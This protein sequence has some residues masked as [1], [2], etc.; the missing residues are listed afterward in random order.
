MNQKME[1]Y[2]D[3]IA[4]LKQKKLE[5]TQQKV[6]VEGGLDED[7]YG[8]IV[9]PDGFEWKIIPNHENGSFYGYDGWSRN[10]CDLMEKH[11]WYVDSEQMPSA[12]KGCSSCPE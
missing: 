1:Q 12:G 10:F 5:Q 7:D 4:V 6:D 11:P 9:P 2:L 3:R 8:R